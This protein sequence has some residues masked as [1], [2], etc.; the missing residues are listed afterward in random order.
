MAQEVLFTT[1]VINDGA[2]R[3]VTIFVG[4]NDVQFEGNILATGLFIYNKTV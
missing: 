4:R 3:R 2:W 1:P